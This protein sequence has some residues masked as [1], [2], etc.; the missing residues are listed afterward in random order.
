VAL[1][2]VILTVDGQRV[3]SSDGLRVVVESKKAG[4][5]VRVGLLRGDRRVEVPVRLGAPEKNGSGTD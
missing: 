3:T 1:G 4:D 5:T 2:D